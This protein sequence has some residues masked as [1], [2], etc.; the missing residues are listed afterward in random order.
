MA[1]TERDYYEILGLPRTATEQEVKRAFRRLARELHPDVSDLPDA[2][3]RFRQVTEA[4][5]VL[6]NPERRELYDRL[7]HAG[8]RSGGFRPGHFD[9]G[10]LSD[11]FAA[12]FGDDLFAGARARSGRGGDVAA[13]VEIDLEEAAR[14]AAVAYLY[15]RILDTY[16]DLLPNPAEREAALAAFGRRFR[17]GEG[18]VLPPAPA[19]VG[20][21]AREP[22]DRAH[23]VLVERCAML[24]A[25]YATLAPAV[26]RDIA[27]LVEPMAAGMIRSSRAFTDQGGVLD[28]G[29]LSRYCRTVI[30][31]PFLFSVRLLLERH[32]GG[33]AVPEALAEDCLAAGEMVQLANVTRDIEKDLRRGIA[34][35]DLPAPPRRIEFS[36]AGFRVLD[37]PG[38]RAGELLTFP[39]ATIWLV[40]E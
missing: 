32:A 40:R 24:D 5:E 23:L 14:G 31:L 16:E 12:F 33:T 3:E 2:E 30:G 8:L 22:R 21:H 18:E 20:W 1:T 37:S 11:I 39:E 26:R 36:L 35:L 7:G 15:C 38:W 17:V 34:E 29:Q 25:V 10:S 28:A 27:D 13:E 4:Y 19:I 6:S 9:F